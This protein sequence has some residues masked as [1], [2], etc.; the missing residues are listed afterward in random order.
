VALRNT[1]IKNVKFKIIE[2]RTVCQ[3]AGDFDYSENQTGPHKTLNRATG[4]TEMSLEGA[5][6]A[7]VAV[8]LS[9]F[10]VV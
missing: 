2:T 9:I 3:Y 7:T 1:C 8:T 6:F 5:L 10:F 4:W